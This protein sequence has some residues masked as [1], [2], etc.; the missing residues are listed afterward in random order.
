[1]YADEDCCKG[2]KVDCGQRTEC[3]LQKMESG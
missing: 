3:Y 2:T 1:M